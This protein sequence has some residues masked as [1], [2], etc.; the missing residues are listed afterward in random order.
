MAWNFDDLNPVS[1]KFWGDEENNEWVE[2]RLI[3][4]SEMQ[5]IRKKLGLKSTQK[6]IPNPN[7]KRM[8]P[9]NDLNMNDEMAVKFNDAVICYQIS[10]WNFKDPQGLDIPC[11]DENKKKIMYGSPVFGKWANKCL[12]EVEKELGLLEEEEEKN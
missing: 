5:N 2:F 9:V 6:Y 4:D 12:K 10:N 1:R 3:N 11:T 7:T 8:E